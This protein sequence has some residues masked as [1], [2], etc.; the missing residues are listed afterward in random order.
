MDKVWFV[1][2]GDGKEGPFD[3]QGLR[4]HP[5]ITPDT[6]VWR[7]GFV[8]WVPLRSVKELAVIFED[9][10]PQEVVEPEE[11]SDL[12]VETEELAIQM[13]S[14]PPQIYYW[15]ALLLIAALLLLFQWLWF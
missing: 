14:E 15:V 13:R 7:E 5:N 12:S 8:F 11:R 2:I 1:Q 10:K 6:L 9:E 4:R 3:V